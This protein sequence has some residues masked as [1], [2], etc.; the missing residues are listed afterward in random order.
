ME[1]T[2]ILLSYLVGSVPF[3][4]VFSKIFLKI[5]IRKIGSGNTGTTNVL[6][7]GSKLLALL[8]LFFDAGKGVFM[9]FSASI[10]SPH[11]ITITAFAVLIGHNFSAFLKLKGGK[12]F[13]TT[14]GYFLY[15][16]PLTFLIFGGIWLLIFLITKYSSLSAIAVLFLMPFVFFFGTNL[17]LSVKI[18]FILISILGIFQHR[19]NIKRLING[20]ENK[21][22]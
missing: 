12:G 4:L 14:F 3:G 8:T 16:E 9:V 18:L 6:R 7:T 20:T 19:E 1:I 21:I 2:W 10:F 22:K 5:D 15:F 17:P 11:L 13:A